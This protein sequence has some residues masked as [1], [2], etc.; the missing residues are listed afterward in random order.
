MAESRALRLA[1]LERSAAD[2]LETPAPA[3]AAR[4]AAG[5][6]LFTFGNGGSA[7][8]ADG[9]GRAVPPTRPWAGRCRRW[10]LVDDQAVLT[11]LANDVGFE[12]VFSRQLI[13]HARPGDIAVGLLDQRQLAQRARAP[14]PRRRA[15]GC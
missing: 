13:A 7:T 12:L 4:F 8:D 3:M 11:A 10:S 5:G 1:T 15:A 2:V 9:A 6:R 14:S